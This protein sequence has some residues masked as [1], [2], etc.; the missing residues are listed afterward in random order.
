MFI[1]ASLLVVLI[2]IVFVSR[3]FTLVSLW[4]IQLLFVSREKTKPKEIVRFS[5]FQNSMDNVNY[6]E[7]ESFDWVRNSVAEFVMRQRRDTAADPSND[8][9]RCVRFDCTD[10]AVS[11]G[12]V[13]IWLLYNLYLPSSSTF[14]STQSA[15]FITHCL[16][17]AYA[18]TLVCVRMTGR[19]AHNRTNRYS[20]SCDNS[21]WNFCKRKI[22]FVASLSLFLPF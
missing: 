20:C 21:H 4:S 13:T 14:S 12:D 11:G 3:G 9:L 22:I 16:H 17:S 8:L 6:L 7:A 15:T 2:C 10:W 18:K 19:Q 1:F 5:L